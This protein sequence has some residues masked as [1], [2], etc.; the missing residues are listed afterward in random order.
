[1]P[2][3][4]AVFRDINPHR[5]QLSGENPVRFLNDL[6]PSTQEAAERNPE[7]LERIEALAGRSTRLLARAAGQPAGDRRPRRLLVRRVRLPRLDAD[8]LGRPRRARGRHPQGGERPGAADDRRRALLPPRLLPS[9][10][11]HLAAGSRSTGSSTTRSRCRWRGSPRPTARRSCSRSSS[12]ARRSHFQVWRVDV[13]RVPLAPPRRG[14]AGE[15]RRPALDDGAALRREP[16]R[17]ARPVRAARDRAAPGCCDALGIEPAVDPPERGPSGARRR[18]S[19]PRG[20]VER[21]RLDGTG[22]RDRSRATRLHDPH[23]GRRGQRDLHGAR[24]SSL[25][26]PDSPAGSGSTTR[27][28][29]TSAASSRRDGR[30]RDDAARDPAQPAPER[31]QPRCTARSRARCGGRCSPAPATSPITHVTNGAHLPT[32]VGD[33]DARPASTGTSA[34]RWLEAPGDPRVVGGG[35]SRSRTRS[36]GR[37]AARPAAAPGRVRP[38]QGGAGQ[39]A[40]R[41]AAR[42]RP[43]DRAETLDPDALTIGFARR[44]ATYKR[45]P[46]ARPRP[47]PG[48]PHLHG[49]PSRAA[50]HRRQGAPERR[51]A[52][53]TRSSAST[54]FEHADA[55]IVGPRRDRRGLRP[56]R[57]RATSSPA[58]TSGSTCRAGRWRRAARAA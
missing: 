39:P 18:S 34:T 52:A 19:S 49:R 3:G 48:A 33:A 51:A 47:G 29:S 8:L 35:A 16:R 13:G 17:P 56:R 58:A 10:A 53:R 43:R 7:L 55:E 12:T 36:C 22:A 21:R 25:P 24:S 27:R 50:P 2:D 28:F 46:P 23:A 40:A 26:T 14:A 41:R 31:R 38:R 30:A 9:A 42:L 57:S 54:D 32:F 11:R 5:W 37:P 20:E 45:A 6:W 4:H 44:L 1:M 15:R